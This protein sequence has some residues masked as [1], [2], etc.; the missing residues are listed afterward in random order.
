MFQIISQ[1]FTN[2]KC[3]LIILT[4]FYNVFFHFPVPNQRIK[5]L[6][7][8]ISFDINFYTLFLIISFFSISKILKIKESFLNFDIITHLTSSVCSLQKVPY[9]IYSDSWWINYALVY[10]VKIL[11][12]MSSLLK[13]VKMFFYIFWTF[14]LVYFNRSFKR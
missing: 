1:K 13:S 4:E 8:L 12:S 6:F 2:Q 9:T 7:C 5:Q 10:S 3:F 11:F 14:L